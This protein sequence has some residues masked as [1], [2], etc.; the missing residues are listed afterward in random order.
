M[1]IPELE[2]RDNPGLKK[3][4]YIETLKGLLRTDLTL[5]AFLFLISIP[6]LEPRDNPGVKETLYIKP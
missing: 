5:S 3:T 1:S 4:L 2:H 6:G